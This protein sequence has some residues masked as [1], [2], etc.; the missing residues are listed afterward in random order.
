MTNCIFDHC[1]GYEGGFV[2][3]TAGR[4][5]L[6]KSVFEN[7]LDDFIFEGNGSSPCPNATL[8]RVH[9][10]HS[11]I[12]LSIDDKQHDT[13]ISDCAFSRNDLHAIDVSGT[14]SLTNSLFEDCKEDHLLDLSYV[15]SKGTERG[16]IIS[17]CT[18]QN[19]GTKAVYSE[20]YDTTFINCTFKNNTNSE[21]KGPGALHIFSKGHF[22]IYNCTFIGNV[23]SMN[24][25]ALIADSENFVEL[26]NSVIPEADKAQDF[27]GAL[28]VSQNFFPTEVKF[29]TISNC[30]FEGNH[31]QVCGGGIYCNF[32]D[33]YNTSDHY[34]DIPIV[35]ENC[36]FIK[37][38]AAYKGGGMAKSMDT[39][40]WVNGDI[41]VNNCFFK[42]CHAKYGC[43]LFSH[44]GTEI[45]DEETNITNCVFDNCYGEI[46][47]SCICSRS[48]LNAFSSCTFQNCVDGS[49]VV[50]IEMDGKHASPAV[51]DYRFIG[52][53]SQQFHFVSEH[54][55]SFGSCLLE[56]LSSE[57]DGGAIRINSDWKSDDLQFNNC[58]FS[59]DKSLNGNGGAVYYSKHE[60]QCPKVPFNGCFFND[61]SSLNG[62]AIYV[63][64]MN[65][66]LRAVV[67]V[68]RAALLMQNWTQT[69]PLKIA[70]FITLKLSLKVPLCSSIWGQS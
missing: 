18:F 54:S 17:D 37:C 7:N 38:S 47:G 42:E 40:G 70:S 66:P 41:F 31:A 3:C 10:T 57:K 20:K 25:G 48:C 19:S 16:T 22:S 21:N 1:S 53:K 63:S 23:G 8:Q 4:I 2:Y 43:G 24:G 30:C 45:G 26:D 34:C 12:L 50:F 36:H 65:R 59:G 55:L 39:P 6:G 28:F 60:S 69:Q 29:V 52:N 61:L 27:G 13:V 32:V 15:L 33:A 67:R 51:T 49:V 9:F 5:I 56:G 58:T 44:D 64:T 14:L 68:I 11:F 35:I 46:A 62:G